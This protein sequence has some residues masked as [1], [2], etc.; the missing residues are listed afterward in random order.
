M[1]RVPL[2]FGIV[3]TLLLIVSTSS[4]V[5]KNIAQFRI[6]TKSFLSIDRTKYGDLYGISYLSKFRIIPSFYSGSVKFEKINTNRFLNLYVLGDSYLGTSFV[7]ND[8][9]FY[10]TK[11]YHYFHL[12]AKNKPYEL[13]KGEKN[14]LL[15]ETVERYLYKF[16][17]TNLVIN[18]FESDQGIIPINH[19][20][21]K[22]A[23]K[24]FPIYIRKILVRTGNLIGEN[25]YK[26]KP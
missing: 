11:S 1:K 9:V 22:I 2:L 14:V 23:L 5:M 4:S 19:L 12:S 25:I 21:H 7:K 16:I 18:S 8:S 10:G 24:R 3:F 6:S 17:D 26:S 15:I 13:V 20:H